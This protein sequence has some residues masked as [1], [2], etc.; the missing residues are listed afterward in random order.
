MTEPV[1]EMTIE[2][3]RDF[4]VARLKKATESF[5]GVPT[6]PAVLDS[7]EAK[8]VSTLVQLTQPLTYVHVPVTGTAYTYAGL[9]VTIVG[10]TDL[11]GDLHYYVKM[12]DGSTVLYGDDELRD[13]IWS[14]RKER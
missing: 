2:Q 9:E 6:S 7:L 4:V 12:P 10:S 3:Q 13:I 1:D 5:I 8:L 11:D 14:V